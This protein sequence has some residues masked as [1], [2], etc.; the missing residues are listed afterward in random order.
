MTPTPA[1]ALADH[2]TGPGDR[3]ASS[4]DQR[5]GG[6]IRPHRTPD[7][8]GLVF[9]SRDRTKTLLEH[10][11]LETRERR[12]IGDWL[13]HDQME[14]FALHG[15]YPSGDWTDDGDL[16][17]WA[18]GK[19]WRVSMTGERTEIPFRVSEQWT[20]HDVPRW[21][22]TPPDTVKS[23]VNRWTTVNRFGDIAYSA[24][25]R[26]IVQ[27]ASGQVHDLGTGFAPSWAQDGRAL[28]WTSWSDADAT[29]RLHITG[30]RGR[31]G[32]T[33]LPVQGQLV[34]PAMSEDGQT[35][36]VL[37][38][39]NTDNSPRLGS[40]PWYELIVLQ[41]DR[42]RWIPQYTGTAVD[43]GMGFRSPRL[44]VHRDRVWWLS[45]GE[46]PNR[47]PA[48]AEW[49][50]TDLRGRD[51]RV[52]LHLEGAVEASP[53]PDFSRLAY[54]LG[55][56]AWV[57]A[58]P[59]PGTAVELK[60]LPQ[61][62]LSDAVGDWLGWTPDG[63]GVHWTEGDTLVTN[64][65]SGPGIPSTPEDTEAEEPP[66]TRL[67]TLLTYAKPRHVPSTTFALTHA[68]VITMEGDTVVEDATVLIEGDRIAAV[69]PEVTIPE[70]AQVLDV[71][72]KTIIPGLIDVHAHLHYGSKDITPEQ[73]WDYN[74]NLDYGVT[75]V[76]DPSAST[77]LVFTQAERVE[78][79]LSQGPR[80]YSTGFV[81]YG[82]LGNENAETPDRTAAHHHVERLKMV[83]AKSVKVY[84]QSRRDQRQWYVEACNAN[85]ILCVAEGGGDLWMNLAMV[86]DGF[87]AIE[88]ALL[89]RARLR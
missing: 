75:T 19:L 52:H 78:S 33:T 89:Q 73:P 11:N 20:F 76:Q 70:D 30:N 12:V 71:K 74:V 54:K 56:Q 31:G 85:Q 45:V 69:G 36:A 83:G 47:E 3:R 80:V 28:L 46:R 59:K 77:D 50:S 37:R 13:D 34:N 40:I 35:I 42:G 60:A 21:P 87:H 15:V 10:L 39:P 17:I 41:K 43:T 7:G 26:L 14:G 32:T 57:T 38:D 22:N 23:R 27:T 24:M 48:K 8:S 84:Q 81:L 82:A 72:G 68:T 53:S 29:G 63:S 25:G 62:Q 18:G 66:D 16:V 1:W 64:T 88:H 55:H 4:R 86:A 67:R 79:G 6:A 49:V 9:A 2:A 58:L 44:T 51:K 61:Y 65:L 5:N